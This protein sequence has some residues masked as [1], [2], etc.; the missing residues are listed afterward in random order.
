MKKSPPK[1]HTPGPGRVTGGGFCGARALLRCVLTPLAS[2]VLELRRN[3]FSFAGFS[4]RSHLPSH[5][6]LQTL[7]R[8]VFEKEHKALFSASLAGAILHEEPAARCTPLFLHVS[9]PMIT[10]SPEGFPTIT[11]SVSLSNTHGGKRERTNTSSLPP[12]FACLMLRFYAIFK[13]PKQTRTTRS[14]VYNL[15]TSKD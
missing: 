13:C 10:H 11:S 15:I 8:D 7:R 5:R 3:R 14:G 12:W 6:S 9:S 1:L 2:S 4:S